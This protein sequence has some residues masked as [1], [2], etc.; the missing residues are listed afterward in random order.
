MRQEQ[1]AIPDAALSDLAAMRDVSVVDLDKAAAELMALGPVASFSDVRQVLARTTSK[2]A[3]T[4]GALLDL[5][6]GLQGLIDPDRIPDHATLVAQ[7]T[8]GLDRIAEWNSKEKARWQAIAPVLTKVLR[9]PC[10]RTLARA[11]DLAF[12]HNAVFRDARCVT[13]LRPVFGPEGKDTEGNADPGEPVALVPTNTLKVRY[14]RD[15]REH[16][17]RLALSEDDLRHLVGV[18]KRALAKTEVLRAMSREIKLPI[19]S[20]EEGDAD[21]NL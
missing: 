2:A 8:E 17:I 6:V 9:A 4:T 7:L 5:I 18:C 16:D 14:H 20:I 19:L 12:E 10:L 13:D 11:Q 15:R 3:A 1:L 21:G